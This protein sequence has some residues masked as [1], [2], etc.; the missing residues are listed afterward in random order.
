M[1][2]YEWA[3]FWGPACPHRIL[4]DNIGWP[5][6]YIGQCE[7]GSMNFMQHNLFWLYQDALQMR[8]TWS[9]SN[10]GLDLVKYY[11]TA[12]WFPRHLYLSYIVTFDTKGNFHVTEESYPS[13]HPEMML[14]KRKKIIVWSKNHRPNG[15]NYIKVFLKPPALL[16]SHWYFARDFCKTTLFT[17]GITAFDPNSGVLSGNQPNSSIILY[18]FPY[19]SRPMP[20]DC[21]ADFCG[22]CFGPQDIPW[23]SRPNRVEVHREGTLNLNQYYI[24]CYDLTTKEYG[25]Q[26]TAKLQSYSVTT[27]TLKSD[28]KIAVTLGRWSV[29]WPNV[30]EGWGTQDAIKKQTPFQYRYSWRDDYGIGNRLVIW[31]RKCLTGIP[32]EDNVL[33]DRPL[34]Q[35]ATGY[36]DFIRMHT[37]H[38][39]LNWVAV[40]NCAYTVPKMTQVVLVGKDWFSKVLQPGKNNMLVNN[41]QTKIKN[42][43]SNTN[44]YK[45]KANTAA[46]QGCV[47]RAPDFV[48]SEPAF[49]ELYLSSPFT[50][51]LQNAPGNINYWYKS[52]W[53]WGGDVPNKRPLEDP[54]QKPKWGALPKTCT[55]ERGVLLENPRQQ[56]PAALI[57]RGDLRR[58]ELTTRGLKRLMSLD[59][60]G[61]QSPCRKKHRPKQAV[62]LEETVE[63]EDVYFWEKPRWTAA[64]V[65][66]SQF[67]LG[68]R[69][70]ASSSTS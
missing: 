44:G 60:T 59:P 45:S 65:E 39:P 53:R 24:K 43:D 9:R 35:L 58:G 7:G 70:Y 57:H 50:I 40:V 3:L 48:D 33:K 31:T 28:L 52:Y 30:D 37:D 49:K 27:D 61:V 23:P 51:K 32:E 47:T 26:N 68:K 5:P 6:K 14:V 41:P 42:W 10:M 21:Y 22:K 64:E 13:L 66:E 2:G 63:P 55:D 34:Y 38:D 62:A 18:G 25:L 16:K 69:D 19:Y 56:E 11:G 12:F 36:Y 15:K 1:V 20:Y 4:Y 17:L 67:K 54:C 46:F 29:I 8:N